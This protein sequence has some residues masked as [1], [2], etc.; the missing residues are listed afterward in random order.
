MVGMGLIDGWRGAKAPR[1][2]GPTGR[3]LMD[4]LNVTIAPSTQAN[5]FEPKSDCIYHATIDLESNGFSVFRNFIKSNSNQSVLGKYNL[6]S[7]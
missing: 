3:R 6:I 4:P 2:P 7:V 1:T 5:T